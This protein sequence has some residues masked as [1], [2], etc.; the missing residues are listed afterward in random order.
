MLAFSLG[1]GNPEQARVR[2]YLAHTDWATRG[3]PDMIIS[4]SNLVNGFNRLMEQPP[5]VAGPDASGEFLR[6][7][8]SQYETVVKLEAELK[9][10]LDKVNSEEV[11][12]PAARYH[13][14]VAGKLSVL[15]KLLAN[16][17]TEIVLNAPE[18]RY[19]NSA[20]RGNGLSAKE[21]NELASQLREAE[22]GSKKARISLIEQFDIPQGEGGLVYER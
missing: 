6:V 22:L 1:C 4:F 10:A 20:A 19:E 16:H 12:E 2:T 14:L 5:G 18:D 17:R 3:V 21:Q 7:L 15:E 13:E 9:V 11:P 8:D